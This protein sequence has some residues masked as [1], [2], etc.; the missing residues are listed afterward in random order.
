MFS[1]AFIRLKSLF[2]RNK[3]ESELGEELQ[4]HLERETEKLVSRGL[5]RT[6]VRD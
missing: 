2:R 4:A 6:V 1:D 5:S 3:V